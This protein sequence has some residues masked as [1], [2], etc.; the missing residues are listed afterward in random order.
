MNSNRNRISEDEATGWFDALRRATF[1]KYK[2]TGNAI[3]PS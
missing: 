2:R 3:N 1:R